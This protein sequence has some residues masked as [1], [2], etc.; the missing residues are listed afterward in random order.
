MKNR[1]DLLITVVGIISL[2]VYQQFFGL[3]WWTAFLLAL[4]TVVII[5]VLWSWLKTLIP[6]GHSH[7]RSQISKSPHRDRG[8]SFSNDAQLPAI[9]GLVPL[10]V[11]WESRAANSDDVV[12]WAGQALEQGLDS[13]ALRILAGLDRSSSR[14]EVDQYFR[15]TLE[16]L[17][18]KEPNF[19]Q[20]LAS[21][22]K[23]IAAQILD[24]KLQ[25]TDGADRIYKISRALDYPAELARWGCLKGGK[26]S[27]VGQGATGEKISLEEAIQLEATKLASS[28]AGAMGLPQD[29]LKQFE[30]DGIKSGRE[31]FLN[32]SRLLDFLQACDQKD[33]AIIGFEAFEIECKGDQ[34]AIINPRFDLIWQYGSK[35]ARTWNEF[36]DG[37]TQ[38]TKAASNELSNK[39]TLFLSFY[40]LVSEKDWEENWKPKS[41]S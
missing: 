33:L 5:A 26:E 41:N 40:D 3:A 32:A 25:P 13:R 22:A 31:F 6:F 11:K 16:D 21:H 15:Q 38:A 12:K 17:G 1:A 23:E 36:R 4:G 24:G 28:R 8:F 14:A 34:V 29:L 30:K 37:C 19:K 2:Y 27:C 18:W 35:Q 20:A 9:P 10:I 39:G 7:A